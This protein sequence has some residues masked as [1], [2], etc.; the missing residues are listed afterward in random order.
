MAKDFD[1]SEKSTTVLLSSMAVAA[2]YG[3]FIS[4]RAICEPGFS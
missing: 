2:D 4:R 3:A 1:W